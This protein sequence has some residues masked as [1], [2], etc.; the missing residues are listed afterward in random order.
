[1]LLI[2]NAVFSFDVILYLL[3]IIWYY[4]KYTQSEIQGSDYLYYILNNK[5]K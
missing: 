3:I 1:M 2:L 5:Y 4:F